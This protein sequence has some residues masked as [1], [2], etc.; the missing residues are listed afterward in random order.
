MDCAIFGRFQTVISRIFRTFNVRFALPPMLLPVLAALWP[1]LGDATT[2]LELD[3]REG[4]QA[5][6]VIVAIQD[7][8][9]RVDPGAGWMLYDS[10]KNTV[11]LVD[12]QRRSYVLMTKAE[13]RRYGEQLAAARK[14]LE[15][16]MQ[17]MLPEQRAALER[18]MGGAGRRSPLLYQ[19]TGQSREVAGYR[20][21]VGRLVRNGKE[22]EKVCLSTPEDID[23]PQSDYATVRGMYQLMHEMQELGAPDILPDFS[24]IDGV[25][26]EVRNPN[27]DFQRVRRIIHERQPADVF[28]VPEGYTREN[29]MEALQRYQ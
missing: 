11:W 1:G 14:L 20:C 5:G 6:Q 13:L 16:Q 18:M 21:T 4:G 15:D 7:G 29:V 28:R 8:M 19:S 12:T 10:A 3:T 27:G 24:E 2:V 26:I 23:M 25:P 9:I 22:K 17:G